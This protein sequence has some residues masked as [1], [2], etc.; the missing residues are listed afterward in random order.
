[1]ED[2][3]TLIIDA[4]CHPAILEEAVRVA[5]PAGRIG[6]LGFSA[7]PSAFPQQESTR[8]ELS[9]FASRLN[10]GMFPR[11]IEWMK[12]GHLQPERVVSHH[13]PFADL[14]R[15]FELVEGDPRASSKVL[16][17]FAPGPEG[18]A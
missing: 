9:L 10:G 16:L 17:D 7:V 18:A 15:A 2:G 14:H 6:M 5:S 3:P 8:K 12:A 11:V 1:V 4:V 13:V